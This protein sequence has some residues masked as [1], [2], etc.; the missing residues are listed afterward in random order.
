MTYGTLRLDLTRASQLLGLAAAPCFALMSALALHSQG[1][2]VFI[3][4]TSKDPSPH[5][6]ATMYMLMSVFHLPPW[7][8][9]IARWRSRMNGAARVR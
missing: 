8:R 5:G 6:M 2:F 7:L 4:C 1:Q 3:L 9:W